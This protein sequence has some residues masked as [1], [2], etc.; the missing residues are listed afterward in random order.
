MAV[1]GEVVGQIGHG[2]LV[3]LGVEADDDEQDA[4]QMA[5][6]VAG[7]RCFEDAESK[8]NLSVEDVEGSVLLISQFTLSGDCRKGRRPSFGT[9]ARPEQAIPLYEAVIGRLRER[10]LPV[11]T[12]VFGARMRVSLVNEGPVTL[13][14]DTKKVF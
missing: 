7:L 11:H 6:K 14:V 2:L 4:R 1:N 5:D 12:G 13:L 3:L 9:A 8:F 10:G